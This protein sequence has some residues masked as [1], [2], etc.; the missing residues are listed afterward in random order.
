[1][2]EEEVDAGPAPPEPAEFDVEK[3]NELLDIVHNTKELPNLQPLNQAAMEQ[4]SK[5]A[6][7]V[8]EEI[9]KRKE[10]HDQAVLEWKAEKDAK[11]KAKAEEEKDAA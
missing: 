8:M 11:A 3:A 10:E 9:A 7:E 1:M 4:L 5:M 6:A 2:V